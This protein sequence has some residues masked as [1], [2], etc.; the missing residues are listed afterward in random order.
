MKLLQEFSQTHDCIM[1]ACDA[2]PL[3]ES[4]YNGFT[5]FVSTDIKKRTDPSAILPSAKGVIVVG[6][7]QTQSKSMETNAGAVLSSLGMDDDYHIRV[8]ALLR[9]LVGELKQ[10]H[11]FKHKILVDS[12]NLDERAFAVRAGLGFLGR[13]GL[14]ISQKFGS[15]FNIGL[16]LHTIEGVAATAAAQ[17]TC[18]P[19]CRMCIDAC[20]AKKNS[21]SKPLLS[22]TACLSYLTQKKELT[23]DEEAS[24]SAA[25]QLYGCDIC[26]NVCPFN[27]QCETNFA[28]TRIWL[29]M[30]DD[31][32]A[33]KYGH[34]AMLWQGTEILRRNARLIK[35]CNSTPNM[36]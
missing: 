16:L 13:N 26:Q 3:D 20:P 33:E 11:N 22:V 5:P 1:G 30:D 21:Q 34:T 25:G 17:Q 15:R 12:P 27:A 24:I 10:H 8:R 32:F 35:N 29:C 4:H 2:S 36:L 31:A 6:V 23:A 19:N 18:S 9:Q 28:D 14:V 7:G